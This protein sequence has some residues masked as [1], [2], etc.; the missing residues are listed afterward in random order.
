MDGMNHKKN[1]KGKDMD[2]MPYSKAEA[3]EVKTLDIKCCMCFDLDKG[4]QLVTFVAF[5]D[6]LYTLGNMFF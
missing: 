2:N 3:V 1:K 5:I 4:I 6:F